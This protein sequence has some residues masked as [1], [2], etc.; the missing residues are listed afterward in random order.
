VSLK[1]SKDTTENRTRDLPARCAVPQPTAAPRTPVEI[2]PFWNS[3]TAWTRESRSNN[4][5]IPTRH[6]SRLI[7]AHNST[8]HDDVCSYVQSCVCL[9]GQLFSISVH[10]RTVL[11]RKTVIVFHSF[12]TYDIDS[13]INEAKSHV[14]KTLNMILFGVI[15]A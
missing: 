15:V 1:N 3:I 14:T 2:I 7:S 8:I 10:K 9:H 5:S 4:W 6:N 12:M 11:I 13:I